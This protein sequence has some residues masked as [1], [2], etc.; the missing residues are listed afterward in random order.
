MLRRNIDGNIET[1]ELQ[2]QFCLYFVNEERM[3][4]LSRAKQKWW[5]DGVRR[6]FDDHTAEQMLMDFYNKPALWRCSNCGWNETYSAYSV[7]ACKKCAHSMK[8][9][10]DKDEPKTSKN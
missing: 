9:Q 2:P 6:Y 3:Q 10:G 7:P 5:P 8:M 1:H 4:Q